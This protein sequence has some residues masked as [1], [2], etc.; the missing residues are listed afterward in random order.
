MAI[1]ASICFYQVF[2]DLKQIDKTLYQ[3]IHSFLAQNSFWDCL[4]P[5]RKDC[6]ENPFH[7]FRRSVWKQKLCSLNRKDLCQWPDFSFENPQLQQDWQEQLFQSWKGMLKTWP[8]SV[9]YLPDGISFSKQSFKAFLR[10]LV[11]WEQ[12]QISEGLS[13]QIR[14]FLSKTGLDDDDILSLVEALQSLETMTH[15]DLRQN[16]I[17]SRGAIALSGFLENSH[18]LE[19][20]DL[21]G[22]PICER[23]AHSLADALKDNRSLKFLSLS[24]EAVSSKAAKA[25]EN[26]RVENFVLEELDIWR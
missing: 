3:Y 22:N 8:T 12:E 13:P 11:A 18:S 14:L 21:Y 20:L 15:L 17:G 23:G 7:L 19:V 2:E 9:F 4:S 6:L 5:I 16:K 24:T 10:S 1:D 25:F 26:V